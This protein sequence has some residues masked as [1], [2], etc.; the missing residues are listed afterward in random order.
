MTLARVVEE[1]FA[2]LAEEVAAQQCQG[3]FQLGVLLLQLV[4]F[5]RGLV[6]H[7]FEFI[8]AALGVIGMRAASACWASSARCP[9]GLGLLPQRV[10]AAQQVFE[11]PPAFRRIVRE[12]QC[13]AHNMNYTRSF[14]LCKSTSADFSRIFLHSGRAAEPLALAG[15][16][17][18]DPGQEHGQ[19]RRLE[20]DAVLGDRAGAS[21]R[22]RPR[23]ACTRWPG[24]P[25]QSRGS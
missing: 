3:L 18:V 14:M 12:L 2:A 1:A 16:V 20:F 19:L 5:G 17:Q 4:V 24:R 7:A 25:G 21:G 11:Q 9:G 13:D 15:R 23:A 10:V 8:D 6:E 22:S